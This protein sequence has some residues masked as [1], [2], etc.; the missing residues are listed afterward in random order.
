M[1][2]VE[3]SELEG[4]KAVLLN[5]ALFV[6]C[7]LVTTCD[8]ETSFNRLIT[9]S[10]DSGSYSDPQSVVREMFKIFIAS[11]S[12]PYSIIT[13]KL[14]PTIFDALHILFLRCSFAAQLFSEG[15]GEDALAFWSDHSNEEVRC[16][17]YALELEFFKD[18]P[19]NQNRE[20]LFN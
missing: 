8:P 9:P 12:K 18:G 6:L 4:Q 10:N 13:L 20:E 5:E 1:E 16:L 2:T 11:L 7:N 15:G 19:T 3:K 14:A 17:A